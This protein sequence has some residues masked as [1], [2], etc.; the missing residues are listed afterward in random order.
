MSDRR[1]ERERLRQQRL[2]A[3]GKRGSTERG[4][5]IAGYVVAGILAVAVVVGLVVVVTSGG[6]SGGSAETPDNANIDPTVG[7]FEGYEPDDREG[8]APPEIQFGDLEQSAQE[9]GCELAL[10]QPMEGRDHFDDETKGDYKANPPT[11]G[12]HFSS[13]EAGSGAVAD[14]AY[15]ST[16]PE[17]RLVHAMEH[18]RVQIRYAPELPE[19]QQLA[20]KGVFDESP[21][22][23]Q[24]VPDPDLPYAVAVSAWENSVGCKVYDPLVLDIVRNFRDTFRGNGPENVAM[25]G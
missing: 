11:S 13:A 10:D 15:L 23:M 9:A 2:A 22:G 14:G 6:D 7:V 25:S 21:G 24:M 19:D 3:Q 20:L 16:P 12:D 8:T 1:E 17:S 4:R 18:G 5:L